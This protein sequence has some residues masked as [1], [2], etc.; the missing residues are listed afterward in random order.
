MRKK[1]IIN[2]LLVFTQDK[3]PVSPRGLC[4]HAHS[5]VMKVSVRPVGGLW[6]LIMVHSAMK[7]SVGTT[8]A[9]GR[10][11]TPENAHRCER[12]QVEECDC[13][14]QVYEFPEKAR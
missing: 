14:T 10:G 12:G 4:V 3:S 2:P 11:D 8:R 7:R 13:P 1:K 9:R 5:G 6:R